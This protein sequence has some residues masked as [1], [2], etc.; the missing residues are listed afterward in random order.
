MSR[1]IGGF[2]ALLAFIPNPIV[3]ANEAWFMSN[4]EK[5]HW[6][7]KKMHEVIGR[8]NTYE[9]LFN[10]LKDILAEFDDS[11]RDA[12]EAYIKKMYED[13]ELES[14][15]KKVTSEYLN[16]LTYSK[17]NAPAV[18]RVWRTIKEFGGFFRN[19]ASAGSPDNDMNKV[20]FNW[21]QGGCVY[22]NSFGELCYAS[23]FVDNRNVSPAY[24]NFCS[25]EK[26]RNDRVEPIA[27]TIADIAHANG[28]T[29]N[30]DD[31]KFYISRWSEYY[32]NGGE[33]RAAYNLVRCD[34]SD[35]GNAEVSTNFDRRTDNPYYYNGKVYGIYADPTYSGGKI[36]IFTFN[37]DGEV[38]G[39]WG[40]GTTELVTTLNPPEGYANGSVQ[41]FAIN[42]DKIFVF[43][44]ASTGVRIAVYDLANG[45][46]CEWNYHMPLVVDNIYAMNEIEGISFCDDYMYMIT[47]GYLGR[48]SNSQYSTIQLFKMD[49][50]NND[51]VGPYYSFYNR[52]MNRVYWNVSS[53]NYNEIYNPNGSSSQPFYC[54]QEAVD[55]ALNYPKSNLVFIIDVL[56]TNRSFT[57]IEGSGSMTIRGNHNIIGGI[58]NYGCRVDLVGC[59]IYF[60]MANGSAD[61]ANPM[62][63]MGVV[64]TYP[65]GIT[66]LRGCHVYSTGGDSYPNTYFNVSRNY[67][68]W[69]GLLSGDVSLGNGLCR[70][71][72]QV[73][74]RMYGT[75]TNVETGTNVSRYFLTSGISEGSLDHSFVF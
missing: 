3:S 37:L 1:Y 63:G 60:S 67:I 54:L 25:I 22:R 35:L 43:Y 53:A 9:E 50:Y 66:F 62:S 74:N 10:E 48:N 45:G 21:A 72:G 51:V 46:D 34:E 68:V 24:T 73:L 7:F 31:K 44:G 17:T 29:Y 59:E 56:T 40:S 30:P 42:K 26:F 65:N 69:T 55:A 71:G 19:N 11:V 39:A 6:L 41:Q 2:S 16:K 38:G 61:S 64:T 33:R 23:C 52:E 8:V 36:E 12:V 13:G 70:D 58:F 20:Y 14:I 27:T 75:F 47:A 15:L 57:W 5:V 32:G 49:F 18:H 4:T 28:M